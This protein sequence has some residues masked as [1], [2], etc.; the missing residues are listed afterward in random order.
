MT[1]IECHDQNRKELVLVSRFRS[2]RMMLTAKIAQ[3]APA[4]KRAA[5]VY[6]EKVAAYREL[7]EAYEIGKRKDEGTVA[8]AA[9]MVGLQVVDNRLK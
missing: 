9:R 2:F 8:A 1:R 6:L 4:V 3:T 7:L 5:T